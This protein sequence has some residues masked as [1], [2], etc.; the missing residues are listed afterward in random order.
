MRIADVDTIAVLGDS[1]LHRI[2]APAKLVAFA[3]VLSAVLVT[4]NV[5]VIVALALSL[6]AVVIGLRLPARTLLSFA[7][8]PAIFAALF[9]LATT[10]GWLGVVLV[11]GKALCAALAAVLLTFTTPYPHIFAPIQRVLPAILGDSALMTYRS[12]FLLLDRMDKTLTS[13]RLRAGRP[14]SLTSGARMATTAL[15]GVLFYSID[16][17][18]RTYDVMRLRGYEGRLIVAPQA[19]GPLTTRLATVTIAAVLLGVAVVSRVWWATLN[20]ISWLLPVAAALVLLG[21]AVARFART[22]KDRS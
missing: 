6:I 4:T 10:A 18:Q 11:V 17:S 15:G 12:L 22:R 13:V 21:A 5:L 7:A 9:A 2:G 16:L 14:K 20:P 3:L 8:Y 1:A 19:S